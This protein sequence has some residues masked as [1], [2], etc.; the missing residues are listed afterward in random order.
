MKL[1]PVELINEC[2]ADDLD[3]K[4]E[5]DGAS[6]T[7]AEEKATSWNVVVISGSCHSTVV[8]DLQDKHYYHKCDDAESDQT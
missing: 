1:L 2:L 4:D 3:E 5:H 7:S 8:V 6:D